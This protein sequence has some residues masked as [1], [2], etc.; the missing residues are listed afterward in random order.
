LKISLAG[1]LG[2]LISL[3]IGCFFL[4][5]SWGI[6]LEHTRIQ[7]YS[8]HASGHITNKH[9]QTAADGS[10]NYYIDYWFMS[11][12][13]NKISASSVI[14]KQ[15]WDAL[16]INDDLGIR[17]DPANPGRN[18]PMYGGSPSLVSAFFMLVLSVVFLVFGALRF[19]ASFKKRSK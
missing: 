18:I 14:S 7:K 2:G 9:F 13:G 15:Q 17:Y 12:G 4:A 8:A 6:Y 19:P 16:Q 5:G 3:G 1:I 10:G 11:S